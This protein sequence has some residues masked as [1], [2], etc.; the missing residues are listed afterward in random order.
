DNF[1]RHLFDLAT[2]AEAFEVERTRFEVAVADRW[3]VS[4]R[5]RRL[6]S[7]PRSVHGFDNEPDADPTDPERRAAIVATVAAP[8]AV[9]L[10]DEITDIGAIDDL[11]AVAATGRD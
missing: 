6:E 3:R 11:I 1:L 10:P 5:P 4:S 9:E 7:E 2:D 8:P